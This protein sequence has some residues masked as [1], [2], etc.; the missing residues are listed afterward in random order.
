M[1]TPAPSEDGP[2]AASR[3]AFESSKGSDVLE[4]LGW[5]DLLS[6]LS[7]AEMRAAVFALFRAQGLELGNSCALGA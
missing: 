6:E 1:S 2:L 5:W 4:A 3:R 7:D